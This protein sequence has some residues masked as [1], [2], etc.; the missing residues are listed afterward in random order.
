MNFDI[1]NKN[2][3][4]SIVDLNK[5][6]ILRG[7]VSKVRNL[8]GLIFIDLRDKTGIVQL[9]VNPDNKNYEKA[10]ELKNEYIIKVSG[11]VIERS[12]KNKNIKTG[13]I[14][15]IVNELDII[16]TSLTPPIIVNDQTDALEDTRLKYRYLD[17]R[18]PVMQNY[19]ILKSKITQVIR[20]YL[21]EKEFL[22]LETPILAKSTPEGARDYLVPSR[23]YKGQF[24]ALPQSPQIF[25]QLYMVAGFERYFQV[26]RCFRDEDLRSDRQPEFTQIDIEASFLSEDQIYEIIEG[27]FKKLFKEVLNVDLVTPFI[28]LT[29]D[30]CLNKYGTDKPDMRFNMLLNDM[31]E[32]AKNTDFNCFKEAEVVKYIKVENSNFS[33]KDI[34]KLQDLA[35]KYRAKGLYWLKYQDNKLTGSVSKFFDESLITKLD[36]KENDLILITADKKDI[37]N[38]AL[39]AVRSNLGKQLNL[40]DE[41]TYKF[42]WVTD[43]PLFEYDSENNKYNSLHHPFT[44]VKEE[45]RKYLE[46]DPLKCL[47]QCYDIVLNGYELGSGSL[48]IYEQLMQEKVFEILGLSED[49]IKNKFGFFVDALKYGTPPHGGIGLGLERIVMIM[50]HTDNIKNVVAFPKTQSAKCLMSDAPST[51]DD[52]QLDDL[53]ISIKEN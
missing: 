46:T 6:V 44:M 2:G 8:G 45:H 9:V 42:L 27:L 7:W 14:E 39:G 48:R 3:S 28:R 17:L 31:T 29:Y 25:K 43:W 38:I 5:N 40:L 52:I 41:N 1:T 15:V 32:I 21:L 51:V 4:L 12:N 36:L 30:E 22:E 13:D 33:R 53:K 47:A 50:T 49:D 35:K 20:N 24:Y 26:A 16:N 23:L 18:R 19:L 10:L 37:A 11:Q 34:D